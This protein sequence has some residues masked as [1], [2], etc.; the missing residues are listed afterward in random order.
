L[1]TPEIGGGCSYRLSPNTCCSGWTRVRLVVH[2]GTRQTKER[3]SWRLLF[4]VQS[5]CIA[6][7]ISVGPYNIIGFFQT[8]RG[9]RYYTLRPHNCFITM[10]DSPVPRWVK[11]WLPRSSIIISF[12]DLN[13]KLRQSQMTTI[14]QQ[15][16]PNIKPLILLNTLLSL[17]MP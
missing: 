9:R 11:T 1:L 3:T 2:L 13:D 4:R 15:T 7:K 17:K 14:K 10:D 16:Q 6:I 5:H 8:M 12:I